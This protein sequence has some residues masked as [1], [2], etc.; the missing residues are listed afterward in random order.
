[1][2]KCFQPLTCSCCMSAAS[3]AAALAASA[4]FSGA[5]STSSRP[6][7]TCG[8]IAIHIHECGK[9]VVLVGTSSGDSCSSSVAGRSSEPFGVYVGPLQP[10]PGS[11]PPRLPPPPPPERRRSTCA[12]RGMTRV[13]PLCHT[14]VTPLRALGPSHP[15][16]SPRLPCSPL[17][18]TTHNSTPPLPHR[19]GKWPTHSMDLRLWRARPRHRTTL[20]IPTHAIST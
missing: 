1:M 15:N 3:P 16:P 17:R 18:R 7:K 9:C 4:A 13:T 8:V 12:R 20:H 6:V 5:V 2:Q 11:E 10:P 19:C 14:C